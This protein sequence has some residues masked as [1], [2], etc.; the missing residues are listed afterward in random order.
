MIFV[1]LSGLFTPEN[2]LFLGNM[3]E[4]LKKYRSEHKFI[5][6][7]IIELIAMRM[8]VS[9][10]IGRIKAK[11]SIEIGRIKAKHSIEICQQEQWQNACVERN[12]MAN[13]LGLEPKLISTI[14]ELIHI[15][16]INIQKAKND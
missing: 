14:Y 9:K 13:A 6:Q 4:D 15:E 5:D 16:S 2:C 12:E 7:Q 8:S 11:H 3:C 1:I 10:E